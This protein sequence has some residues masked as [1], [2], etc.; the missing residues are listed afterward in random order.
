MPAHGRSWPRGVV[1]SVCLLAAILVVALPGLALAGNVPK[2]LRVGLAVGAYVM[3]LLA[4]T[5]GR[6]SPP[7]GSFVAAG[8]AAGLVSGLAR[9]SISAGVIGAGVVGAGF[10]LG[11]LHWLALRSWR[12]GTDA[13]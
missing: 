3:V 9:G 2:L 13:P 8:V 1:Q 10:L 6:A 5:R 4:L 7:L 12:R 11:P